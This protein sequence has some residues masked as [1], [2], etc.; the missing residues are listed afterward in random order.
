MSTAK[1]LDIADVNVSGNEPGPK[2]RPFGLR[3]KLGYLFGDFG[4]DFFFIL[5]AI[6]L[7]VFYTDV[8]HI[9]PAT[10]GALFAV[11]RLW[12]AF[13]DV[14]WGRFIDTR[15]TTPNGKFR[16]WILRMSFPLVITGVLMFVKIPGMSDGFYL[17]WAFVTYIVWGTLYSTVNI[18][19]GSMASVITDDPV[20]RT[21]LSGWRTMGA[22]AAGL[23]I[24]VG[25]PMVVFVDNQ[26]DH[27]RMLMAAIVFGV[28][29][30]ACYIACYKMVT[31]RVVA[32][33]RP[34]VKGSSK[35]TMKG[36]IKNKPLIWILV[37]SLTFMVCTMLIQSVNIFLFKDYFANAKA[38]SMVNLVT[39]GTVFLLMPFLSPLVKRFGKKEL[40]AAGMLLAGLVY[41]LLFFLKDISAMQFVGILTIG[42]LGNA[43]FNLVIWAF[44]TDV[45]D[46][47][48]YITNL[49]EDATVY[50][51]Y[52]M[53]RK[54]G[55]AVAGGLGG[56][57]IG[58]VGYNSTLKVQTQETLDGIHAL[59]TLL[60]AV[61]FLAIFL[62]IVFFYPL[63]KQRTIQLAA[64]LAD[65]RKENNN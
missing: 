50:S 12:D 6:F 22:Q 31:E 49:R 37:A 60:P 25:G 58:V 16:P 26:I 41:L 56:V 15:K 9:H 46:Y 8:F 64:D 44:V 11:A 47:H 24:G 21:S 28:L 30:L 61:I 33:E 45:I 2:V 54:V 10:V 18:P 42:M 17:A 57:L 40:A 59:G 14:A 3:D 4:N 62:I 48:E 52:S 20:E 7:M 19:Y 53:A 5:V 34:K 1:K 23:I 43:I 29:A 63:N 36:L 38:V 13:A 39:S 65:R 51:I 32:P 27:N 35:A 55:Q